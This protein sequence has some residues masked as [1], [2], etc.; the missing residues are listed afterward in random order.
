MKITYEFVTGEKVEIEV[1]KKWEDVMIDLNLR[2]RRNNH[3]ETRRHY[4]LNT[5]DDSSECLIDPNAFVEK[6]IE[7]KLTDKEIVDYARKHLSEKQLRVFENMYVDGLTAKECAEKLGL[8]KSAV[9]QVLRTIRKKM[10]YF[11]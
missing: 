6:I 9:S 3:T 4:R 10:K 1:G 8:S 7:N 11:L 5:S 2:E